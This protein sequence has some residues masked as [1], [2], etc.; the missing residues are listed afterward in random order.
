M[1]GGG[2]QTTTQTASSEPWKE[3]QPYYKDVL[4]GAQGAYNSGNGF[5]YYPD[6]TVVPFS[7]QT[8][9]ALGNIQ[10]L[11][12]QGNPLGV[13]AQQ[14]AGNVLNSGG[15][16]DWQKAALGGTYDIATGA[17]GLSTEGDYRDLLAKAGGTGEV[18]A[19]LQPYAR[20]DYVN[21][22]SPEFNK[23]L[24]VQSGKLADDIQRTIGMQGRSGS[25]YNTNSLVEGVGNLRM[26]AMADE[27]AR[28][29]GQQLQAAGMLGNEQQRGFGNAL[30]AVG[31]IGQT[32]GANLSNMVG[33]GSQISAAGNQA[34][35]QVAQFAGLAPSIYDQQFAPS[36]RLA[37]VGAANEDLATRQK[38]DQIARYNSQQQEPW[39]RLAAYNALIGGSGSLGG[40]QTSTAQQPA[41]YMA[42][43]G[44]AL[45]G[46]QMGS[47]FGPWGAGIGAGLGGLAGLF[48]M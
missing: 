32:Q 46:A 36:E 3:A 10:N 38:N 13:A 2:G 37:S 43:F 7:S 47:A 19:A 1:G 17:K 34:A 23:A 21:G 11:A 48:G 20:G 35:N 15:M 5:K 33:A 16:S 31:G 6:S 42:P 18:G 27:I 12:N 4:G 39:S 8:N 26:S 14:Q 30:S 44:G 28:Q 25:A 41:N 29:Q 9:Q 40:T 22:G 45:A 24:D